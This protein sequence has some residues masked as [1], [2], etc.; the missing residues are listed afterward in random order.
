MTW[1]T[2]LNNDCVLFTGTKSS[3]MLIYFLPIRNLNRC[4]LQTYLLCKI[5]FCGC[6]CTIAIITVYLPLSGHNVL[7][8]SPVSL[9]EEWGRRRVPA[10]GP[11]LTRSPGSTKTRS[12]IQPEF[13]QNKCNKPDLTVVVT[14]VVLPLLCYNGC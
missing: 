5:I 1:M 7:I 14:A 9:K 10:S 4:E 6:R 13:I 3:F 12:Y 11:L 8:Y 2:F